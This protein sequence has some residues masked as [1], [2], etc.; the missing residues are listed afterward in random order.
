MQVSLHRTGHKLGLLAAAGFA[1]A[2]F[3]FA[4]VRPWLAERAAAGMDRPT[5]E[6]AVALEPQNALH[7]YRLGRFS[8]F[9]EQDPDRAEAHYR[10]AVSLNPSFAYGWFDLA[11]VYRFRG[12]FESEQEALENAL[13]ADPRN[14]E[15]A[16]YAANFFLARGETDRAHPLI[17]AVLWSDEQKLQPALAL[18]WR[19]THDARRIAS[20]ALPQSDRYYSAFI[21]YVLR[22]HEP[23]AADTVWGVWMESGIATDAKLALRYIDHLISQNQITAARRAWGELSQ[24][25]SDLTKRSQPGNL[26]VNGGFEWEILGG[27]FEWRYQRT[28]LAQLEIDS[29]T[30]RSGSRSLKIDFVGDSGDD[31][32]LS[33]LIAVEPDTRYAFSALVR[34]EEIRSIGRPRFA[35]HDAASGNLLFFSEELSG[36]LPWTE[37]GGVFTTGPHTALVSLRLVRDGRSLIRGRAWIDDLTLRRVQP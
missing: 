13:E 7:H 31:I 30:F 34:T 25:A 22:E 27:G 16:W 15:V 23:A 37:R 8:Y 5:L 32:G 18:C 35:I 33:Q 29:S 19:A 36:T 28:P 11:A 6:R 4:N 10:R 2:F 14:P 24:L 26:I 17:R 9:V 21:D 3:V 20:E 12:D 1:C